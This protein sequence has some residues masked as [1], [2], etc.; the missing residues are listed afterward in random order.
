MRNSHSTRGS[1]MFLLHTWKRNG[2]H[3]LLETG[4]EAAMV[5]IKAK[6]QQEPKLR[7]KHNVNNEEATAKKAEIEFQAPHPTPFPTSPK[8]V[9]WL[10]RSW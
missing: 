6:C 4:Q 8:N 7:K 1:W 9:L 10:E 2:V 5:R 3:V